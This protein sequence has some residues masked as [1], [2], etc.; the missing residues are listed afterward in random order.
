[1]KILQ[2]RSMK[3][4]DTKKSQHMHYLVAVAN[5]V[6]LPWQPPLWYS[7]N[8]H[9]SSNKYREI[10]DNIVKQCITA[11]TSKAEGFEG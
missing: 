2:Y 6:K 9:Y 5:N 7:C 1:M 10:H 11:A 4:N 3:T 8:I